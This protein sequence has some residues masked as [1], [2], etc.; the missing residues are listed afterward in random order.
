MGVAVSQSGVAVPHSVVQLTGDAEKD[1]AEVISLI[2]NLKA[3][4]VVVGFPVS[5]SGQISHAAESAKKYAGL[6]KKSLQVPVVL[7]DERFSSVE[8]EKQ[9][10]LAGLSSKKAR[11]K[12]DMA[13]A[14]IILQSWLDSSHKDELDSSHKDELDTANKRTG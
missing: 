2:Q 4:T 13:A 12:V 6:L 7:H 8:A 9:L 3:E 14:C 5:L 1:M 11:V 10:K